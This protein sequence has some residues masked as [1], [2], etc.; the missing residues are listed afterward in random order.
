MG[1]PCIVQL[2]QTRRYHIRKIKLQGCVL[3]QFMEMPLLS[4]TEISCF[5]CL[6]LLSY[7]L[8]STLMNP[9]VTAREL[10]E[11]QFLMN[12]TAEVNVQ[13]NFPVLCHR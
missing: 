9:P 3:L 11:V 13:R 7:K 10:K 4:G 8:M 2:H 1:L 12:V 6:S 5:S